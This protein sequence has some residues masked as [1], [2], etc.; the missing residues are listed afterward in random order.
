MRHYVVD[1]AIPA[2]ELLRYYRGA[3]AAVIA[4]DRYG[5]AVRFPATALRPYVTATGVHGRFELQV[6]DANRLVAMQCLS[7]AAPTAG[8][9]PGPGVSSREH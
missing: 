4:H 8:T 1:L 6:D 5:R 9:V 2:I 3:A 7:S